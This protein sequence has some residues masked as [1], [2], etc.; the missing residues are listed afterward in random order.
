[1]CAMHTVQ[2]KLARLE[3]D[4]ALSYECLALEQETCKQAEREARVAVASSEA[5]L[6]RLRATEECLQA[7]LMRC[8]ELEFEYQ[9]LGFELAE[10]QHRADSL[11]ESLY[12]SEERRLDGQDERL[13]LARRLSAAQERVREL[14]VMLCERGSPLSLDQTL[15]ALL[16]NKPLTGPV[17]TSPSPGRKQVEGWMASWSMS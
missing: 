9:L 10:S 17:A 13:V 15:Q 8:R 2:E 4:L 5:A 6:M 14:E 1:M 3:V 7:S 12:L 11:E 16:G